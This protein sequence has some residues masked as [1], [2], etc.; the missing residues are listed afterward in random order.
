MHALPDGRYD[1]FVI[2]AETIDEMT[3]RV[4]IAL[5]SGGDRG[6]I[7]AVRGPHLADDPVSLLGLPGTLDV[8]DGVPRLT[9]ER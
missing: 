7:I 5:V 8:R 2:D 1:V 9:I 6:N 3:M 4:E